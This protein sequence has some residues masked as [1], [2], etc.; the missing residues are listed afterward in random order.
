MDMGSIVQ[1]IDRYRLNAIAGETSQIVQLARYVAGLSEDQRTTLQLSVTKA[2]YTSEPMTPRQR[3]FVKS[4][5]PTIAMS[6][7]IGS[8]EAGPWAASTA[9]LTESVLYREYADFIFDDR[10]IHLEFLPFSIKEDPSRQTP[11]VPDGEKVYWFRPPFS[12]CVIRS[13]V[14]SAATLLLYILCQSR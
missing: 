6:S 13:C 3:K 7:F 5:S 11:S 14:M 8:A 4:I 10:L 12:A 2:E 1:A 9:E